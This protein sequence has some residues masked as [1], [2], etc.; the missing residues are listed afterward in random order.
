MR[1]SP[2]TVQQWLD[3][4]PQ[5]GPKT[6]QQNLG[7]Q[8]NLGY[9]P[10]SP[11]PSLRLLGRDASVQSDDCSHCS[12]VESVLEFRKPDPE[13][14]LLGLGF[15][16]PNNGQST[17][18]IPQRFLQPSKLLTQIDIN[19]FLEEQGEL[20]AVDH[21]QFSCRYSNPPSPA[22]TAKPKT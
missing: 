8:G 7:P 22:R 5:P 14:V 16:P 12:S 3:T 11:R 20:Q 9:G 21:F 13:A 1:K 10:N 6:Q 17:S 19:K 15:G 4:L 18:R 2:I